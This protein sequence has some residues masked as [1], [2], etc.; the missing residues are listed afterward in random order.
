[1]RLLPLLALAGCAPSHV[2]PGPVSDTASTQASEPP[3]APPAFAEAP[4]PSPRIAPDDTLAA[5]AKRDVAEVVRTRVHVQTDKPLYRPGD[6]IWVKTWHLATATLAGTVDRAIRYELVGPRGDVVLT[7]SVEQRN[8]SATNDF[9]LPTGAAGGAWV[10]RAASADGQRAER[11]IVVLGYEAP[12][13]KKSLEFV[14]KAYVP[15]DTVAATLKV[16]SPTGEPLADHPITGL[17]RID[18]RDLDKVQVTTNAAGEAMVRFA[19]PAG[20]DL[21][22]GLLTV[23]VDESGVT[24]SISRRIPIVLSGVNVAVYPEG[25]SLVAGL[26]SRVYF[27][28]TKADGKPAD[29]SGRIV[30]D[31]GQVLGGFRTFH[32]GLGRFELTPR[33]GRTYH[34]EVVGRSGETPLPAALDDGCVLRTHDD[35]ATTLAAL[36]VDVRCTTPREVSVVGSLRGQVLD[37]ARVKVTASRAAT[38]Y[39]APVDATLAKAAGVARVTLY[40][41]DAAPIAERVVMRNR[42]QRL[43]LTVKP[44]SERYGPRDIV[45]LDVTATDPSG[46]PVVADV[47]VS[48]VDDTVLSYA[49]DKQG[50]IVT[51]LLVEAEL[52][53]PVEEPRTFF[54]EPTG[55]ALDLLLGT[56]GWRTFEKVPVAPPAPSEPPPEPLAQ[57]PRPWKEEGKVG[58][59]DAPP[60]RIQ[61]QM[62][63]LDREVAAQ[64]GLLDTPVL[65][66]LAENA[67]VL[68][69]GLAANQLQQVGG[70]IGGKGTAI[71]GGGLG[72][73]GSGFGGGNTAEGVGG[74]GARGRGYGG[75]GGN[76]G[77]KGSGSIAVP[78][79]AIVIGALDRSLIDAVVKR[80]L[81]QIR[82]CYQRELTKNP[83]LAGKVT[84][85]FVIQPD[86]VVASAVTKQSTLGNAAVESC[87]NGRFLRFQFPEPKGGGIVIVS[88]PFRFSADAVPAG[89]RGAPTDPFYVAD[90]RPA[91]ASVRVFPT[92]RHVAGG[93]RTD[94]RDTVAWAP[95]VRTDATG[96]ARVT[97]SL[98][99]AVTSFRVTAEGVG[100]GR[101]GRGEALLASTLPF[102][103][104]VKLPVAAV[105]GDTMH[106]PLTLTND[107]DTPVRVTVGATLGAPA[108]AVTLPGRAGQTLFYDLVAG[109]TVGGSKVPVSF[110]ATSDGLADAFTRTLDVVDAGFP[111]TWSASGRLDATAAHDL[112]LGEVIEGSARAWIKLYPNALSSMV[113]GM[114]GLLQMPHG[115]FEQA[116]SSNYPNL[117]VLR[118]LEEQGVADTALAE[119]SRTLLEAGYGR[120]TGYES[121]GGGY[122]WFGGFPAH[123]SLT[124]YGVAQ[125]ADMRAVFP[126]VDD[127][128]VRRTASWLADRRDGAGGWQ[129]QE[130][131]LDGFGRAS[132]EVTDAYI[133]WSLVGAGLG[134]GLDKE[135]DAQAK[136]ART[137]GDAYLLA[138]ATSTLLPTRPDEGHAAADRLARL[139]GPGG[140]WRKADHSITRSQGANLYVET[141]ALATLALLADGRHPQEVDA[142]ARWLVDQ[143]DGTG[144]WGS[145]QA[146]VL[147]LKALTRF[148][149]DQPPQQDGT[150][151]VKV[152]GVEAGRVTW[153]AKGSTAP[154]IELPVVDGRHTITVTRLDGDVVPY[155][156]GAAWSTRAP[157]SHPAV[158]VSVDAALAADRV[159]MGETVRLTA[160]LRNL[161]TVGQPMALARIGIPAGL[162][163]QTWQLDELRNTGVVDY[164]ETGANEV[165]V[166]FRALAPGAVHTVPI[167]LL[168]TVPGEYVAPASRAYLYYDDDKVAWA[169]PVR[170]AVSG[171]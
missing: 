52:P 132:A 151:I 117:L 57:T 7:K 82:Y 24:E 35:L 73:R 63:Q 87:I 84:V 33:P 165:I 135:L 170:V 109:A 69:D 9:E 118:Y 125:F 40:D 146:T 17:V 92:P 26:P 70:L 86:G 141:T 6:T 31:R 5:L 83:T 97:F 100:G 48:V 58:K 160:H 60:D 95:S 142:A 59:R 143:R 19:L 13:L 107:R 112:D 136:L 37:A 152:D 91:Y 124:A 106:I 116:S 85:K 105:K 25:G 144:R 78:E 47:A 56:A 51:R 75:G 120:L 115:C 64:A 162:S 68:D 103:M 8:G 74:L 38:V 157:L 39:L 66:A 54:T 150:A 153:S 29:V 130:R 104:A 134:A 163:V 1:M 18:G 138:L 133:A 88:Y 65:G 79:Q 30:D 46:A 14:R 12:R 42:D 2:T 113:D 72:A 128:M 140:A 99:D 167:D 76:F 27:A 45:A 139:Q 21:G 145:T 67:G 15:G 110:S 127:A 93:P 32:H 122:E 34:L 137:T 20:M 28:A 121:K 55:Y 111:R 4:P 98:S 89:G 168:A 166:Y 44:L 16:S 11:R 101:V 50:D 126:G 156:L 96:H 23:L 94:F 114:E 171:G 148:A 102:S 169:P 147:T 10:V 81:A 49:D 62:Q 53:A 129:Q 159:D 154:R 123:E 90:Y 22:D 43:T 155:T 71:G 158:A 131:A 161:A 108:R 149:A 80:N 119:R 3:E 164:Y 36:R 61:L 41:T 77:S